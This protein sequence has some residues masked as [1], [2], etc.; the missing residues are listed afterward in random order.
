MPRATDALLTC[1]FMSAVTDDVSGDGSGFCA[2]ELVK[3][4]GCANERAPLYV[5][6]Q[7]ADPMTTVFVSLS[8][9]T[10]QP[11]AQIQLA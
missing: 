11:A 5:S 2:F 8:L 1:R 6:N 4:R 10:L 9:G 7:V 3:C